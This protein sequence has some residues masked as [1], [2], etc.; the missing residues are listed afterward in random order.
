MVKI[1]TIFQEDTIE[2]VKQKAVDLRTEL[3][4][5]FIEMN[6]DE[7]VMADTRVTW[8]VSRFQN[9]MLNT[10]NEQIYFDTKKSFVLNAAHYDLT[11]EEDVL[12]IQPIISALLIMYHYFHG[13]RDFYVPVM[14]FPK[15]FI[16][17][18]NRMDDVSLYTIEDEDELYN[19][20]KFV[21]DYFAIN[22]KLVNMDVLKEVAS[23]LSLQKVNEN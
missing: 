4:K 20:F 5:N 21:N 9:L 11:K 2:A 3:I 1:Y 14:Q 8:F 23:E 15:E 16:N 19:K 12:L 10:P 6:K 13:A 7:T 17:A 22:N 18:L